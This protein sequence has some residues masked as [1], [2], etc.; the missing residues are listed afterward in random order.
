MSN[1]AKPVRFKLPTRVTT[2]GFLERSDPRASAI[3][4]RSERA[5]DAIH[6][7][8]LESARRELLLTLEIAHLPDVYLILAGIARTGEEQAGYLQ[9]VL[10]LEPNNAI[11]TEALAILRGESTSLVDGDNRARSLEEDE[12]GF[13][14]VTCPQ[15]Q[16]RLTY[17]PTSG[18]VKCNFCN[19]IVLDADGMPQTP[20]QRTSV[21]MGLI[22]RKN[23][24]NDWNLGKWWLQ[25]NNCGACITLSRS[26][27]TNTCR[28]CDS[29]NIVKAGVNAHFEQP[30]IIVPLRVTEEEA[31]A[32]ISDK[33][34]SGIRAFTRFFADPIETIKLSPIYLPFWIF[35]GEVNVRWWWTNSQGRGTYPI[36]LENLLFFADNTLPRHLLDK[37]EPF[38][39]Q[40]AVAYDPRLL[41]I[42]PAE[43]YHIDVD[44]ASLE[45]RSKI[46]KIGDLK[47]RASTARLPPNEYDWQG[48]RKNPGKFKTSTST[49]YLAYRLGLLP[50]W[51]GI[52]IEEDGDTRQIVVN[53]Q[54]AE[55][56]LGNLDKK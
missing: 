8:N 32:A 18:E 5:L 19:F 3:L 24:P 43:I 15:C 22:R 44:Q 49:N 40:L 54:T 26:T 23:R 27:L 4:S 56:A 14:E 29:R 52:L 39:L 21:T 9:S 36:L 17:K 12:V 47:I 42:Y 37:I 50:V 51:V 48:N 30:D 33:L 45:V 20:Q 7:K 6:R 11:A 55:V 41:A 46:R 1:L 13:K 28:F 10:T 16:G 2:L 53:G 35:E 34:K 31:H 38:N 25:C